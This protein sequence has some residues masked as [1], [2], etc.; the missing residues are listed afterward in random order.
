MRLLKDKIETWKAEFLTQNDRRFLMGAGLSLSLLFILL[1]LNYQESD[2]EG[3]RQKIGTLIVKKNIVQRKGERQ[4]IWKTVPQ[5]YP[6]YER[7]TIRTGNQSQAILYLDQK[8]K[9][10]I[11]ENTLI[12]LDFFSTSA[13]GRVRLEQGSARFHK[14]A[15]E[16]QEDLDLEF[17][18]NQEQVFNLKGQGGV[19]LGRSVDSGKL[20]VT[21]LNDRVKLKGAKGKEELL[22]PDDV[23]LIGRKDIIKQ[24]L[25]VLPLEPKDGAY[26]GTSGQSI[27]AVDF[28]WRTSGSK[29]EKLRI[30]ISKSLS[31]SSS[32]VSK[33]LTGTS[34]SFQSKLKP[35]LYY[36]RIGLSSKKKGQSQK[37]YSPARKFRVLSQAA[38]QSHHPRSDSTFTYYDKGAFINFS[39]AVHPYA[40]L[41]LLEVTS[42][43][44]KKFQ[45]SLIKKRLP[46]VKHAVNLREGKYLWRVSAHHMLTETVLVSRIK[47][48]QVL[49]E[50]ERRATAADL[51]FNFA[52]N[53]ILNRE[54]LGRRG[55]L[56]IWKDKGELARTELQIAEDPQFSQVVIEAKNTKNFYNILAKLPKPRYYYQ[57]KAYNKEGKLLFTSETRSFRVQNLKINLKALKPGN[58]STFLSK[59]AKK[60]I[61]FSWERS[62]KDKGGL[63][64]YKLSIAKNK[65]F[66][67][68]IFKKTVK[69]E[70]FSVKDL[71]KR[72]RYFWRVQA[73]DSVDGTFLAQ[74][75][76]FSF[77]I[78]K[79]PLIYIN[80]WGELKKIRGIIVNRTGS[81]IEISCSEG[82]IIINA[83]QLIK[84]KHVYDDDEDE[85]L[86]D[87][88]LLD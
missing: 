13:K 55:S 63:F 2:S 9:I 81:L 53:E 73:F 67:N 50:K 45:K 65:N 22:L 84:V 79:L 19:F 32:T 38:V 61:D 56:L 20:E 40:N 49:R 47:G 83:S 21:A 60:G 66:I 77:E 44:D 88:K 33:E 54:V 18:D 87:Q 36:W 25:K 68:S 71:K 14:V 12:F 39:W 31:F 23:L 4:V 37:K 76:S 74:T 51:A 86:I 80:R 29:K 85:D 34:T 62:P 11:D 17:V 1:Y 27:A 3:E 48:F 57:L 16:S 7:D 42:A 82:I 72:G 46:F 28:R 69:D 75:Q 58:Q 59:R 8:F 5:K 10:D 6:V 41:Y 24:K 43:E 35:G 78:K 15:A 52:P 26:I 64:K 70:T 30:E